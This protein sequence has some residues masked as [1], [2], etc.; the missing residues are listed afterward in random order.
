MME[1]QVALF[2]CIA[3]GVFLLIKEYLRPLKSR[4]GWRMLASVLAVSSFY[5]LLYPITYQSETKTLPQEIVFLTAG[6]P[7]SSVPTDR[8]V[9]TSDKSLQKALKGTAEYIPDLMLFLKERP[10]IKK[11]KLYGY[12]LDESQLQEL[13]DYE[14]DYHPAD[15]PTGLIV[16][17]WKHK[18]NQTEDLL[19]QGTYHHPGKEPVKLVLK[20]LG[21]H[22]DSLKISP[23][24]ETRF[25][26]KTRPPLSGRAIYQVLALSGSDTLANE[27]VPFDLQQESPMRV[28]MLASFPDFEYKFLK[29]WLYERKYPVIFRTQISKDKYSTDYLNT[30]QTSVNT[31]S[32][33]VLKN[34]DLVVTDEETWGSL[35]AG[36]KAAI[37]A[38]IK[39]GLGMIMRAKAARLTRL[40]GR[41]KVVVTAIPD[42]YNLLLEG[43]EVAYADFWS[44]LIKTGGRKK[45]VDIDWQVL[46]KYP[47]VGTKTRM[48]V[49]QAT[50]SQMPIV[51]VD[52]DKLALRQNMEKPFQ[53]DTYFWPGNAGWNITYINKAPAWFYVFDAGNWANSR[54]YYKLQQ[55][56]AHVMEQNEGSKTLESTKMVQK[57]SS[58][59]WYFA[60]FLLAA[61]YL[62]YEARFF[63]NK[64]NS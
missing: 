11:I 8:Q 27:P 32:T 4:M 45:Q 52:G 6:T 53:W 34:T 23:G 24:K 58:V 62:W 51:T 59:W 20:G 5:F 16:A 61:G 29:N 46:P 63:R 10:E 7:T 17:N 39:A 30:A 57:T 55:N 40:N 64:I 43:K 41:G 50:G 9:Y 48:L 13:K 54:S 3:L 2:M 26:F 19:L 37:N 14:I 22:L 60:F 18:I 21:V 42:S 49:A 33:A 44:A 31:I 47:V 38:E 36:E 28:L 12:G 25:S 56:M 35:S 1:Q 15:K